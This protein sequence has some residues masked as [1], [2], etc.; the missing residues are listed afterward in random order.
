MRIRY[1]ILI[2]AALMA[3]ASCGEKKKKSYDE[4]AMSGLTTRTENLKTN[5]K[6]YACKSTLIGQMYGTLSG[7]GWNRWECDSNRCDMKALCGY[8][9][10]ANGYELS[11]IESGKLQNADGVPFKTIRED[12]LTHFRKGGLLIMNWTMPNYN[13]NEELLE[14]YAK[15]HPAGWL[16]HQ[17]TR[18]T[19]SAATGWKSMVLPVG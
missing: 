9:P 6:S 11:G 16:R 14:E 7:I 12:V 15:R 3:F 19:P 1:F 17:G 10:A 2:F 18:N 4:I 5:I 8:R 13:G